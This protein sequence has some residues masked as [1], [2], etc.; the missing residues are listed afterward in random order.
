MEKVNIDDLSQAA[1]EEI[2]FVVTIDGATVIDVANALFVAWSLSGDEVIRLTLGSGIA[3]ASSTLTVAI[4][5]TVSTPLAGKYRYELWMQDSLGKDTPLNYGF[6]KFKD[7]F[8]R[9]E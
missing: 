3:F 7:T 5:D 4:G 8:G 2:D 9:Y 1:D 6:L